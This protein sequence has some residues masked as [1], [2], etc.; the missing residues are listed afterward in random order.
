MRIKVKIPASSGNLGPG[1]DTLGLALGL[2]NVLEIGE[3]SRFQMDI[4]GAGKETL[5]RDRTNLVYRALKSLYQKAGKEVRPLHI[6]MYNRIPLNRGL[7]SS[8]AAIVGGLVAGNALLDNPLEEKDILNLA[9]RWE[10]HPDNVSPSLL[11][12]LVASCLTE[13]GVKFVKI[14]FP[15]SLKV[16][17]Q[18]PEIELSTTVARRCLPAKIPSEDV[19]FNLQRLSLF[20][21]SLFSRKWDYLAIATEDRVHQP[22]R[23]K[24]IP[25]LGEVME[26]ARRAGAWG[27]AL[28]G[29]G[30]SVLAFAEEEKVNDIIEAMK[31][32]FLKKGIS[33]RGLCLKVAWKGAEVSYLD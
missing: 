33:S 24:L 21:A 30:P 12:G 4:E 26:S 19:R 17:V 13:E 2:Y 14:P 3:S 20:L 29:A 18:I 15:R 28:S 5:P 9:V 7:G 25:G 10:G 6:K 32:G 16:V 1:F 22:Y 27:V 8:G 11:G 31:K 23:E